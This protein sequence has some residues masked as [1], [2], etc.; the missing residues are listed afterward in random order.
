M[1][2][3]NRHQ[4]IISNA[5]KALLEMEEAFNLITELDKAFQAIGQDAL[6]EEVAYNLDHDNGLE[7]NF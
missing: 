1:A 6:N 7:L 4:I 3:Q 5:E 2:K